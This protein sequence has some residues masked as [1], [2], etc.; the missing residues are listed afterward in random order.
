MA[1][2][3]LLNPEDVPGPIY[4]RKVAM[5]CAWRMHKGRFFP[6][7][8]INVGVGAAHE[9]VIWKWLYPAASIL[10]IDPRPI[11]L[12]C[13][14]RHRG[15][16][17][18]VQAVACEKETSSVV[19]CRRCHSL[20]CKSQNA[21]KDFWKDIKRVAID[22]LVSSFEPPYFMWLDIEGGEV[23]AL[24]GAM[25]TL[26]QAGWLCTELTNWIPGHRRS[27]LSLLRRQGFVLS[28]LFSK[29]GLFYNKSFLMGR[30][31]VRRLP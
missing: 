16:L 4:T 7:T 24:K 27:L 22:D 30:K 25:Q 6:K 18:F 12:T 3:N 26:K 10:A 15:K 13:K 1:F 8:I 28:T 21:H 9:L 23:D 2:E 5:H 31:K 11:G 14:R 20:Y 29:D 17:T 19:Y